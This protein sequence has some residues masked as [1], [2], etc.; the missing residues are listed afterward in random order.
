MVLLVRKDSLG[1]TFPVLIIQPFCPY[2]Y[3]WHIEPRAGGKL[4]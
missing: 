4:K 3:E 1:L 2:L